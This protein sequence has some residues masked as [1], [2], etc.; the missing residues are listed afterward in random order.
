MA[1]EMRMEMPDYINTRVTEERQSTEK[2]ENSLPAGVCNQLDLDNINSTNG[3][4]MSPEN[5]IELL[6]QK[7]KMLEQLED[8]I[9]KLQSE[10]EQIKS[11]LA[12]SVQDFQG[13]PVGWLK[14]KQSC[15]QLNDE[16][17]DWENAHN[18]CVEK[19]SHLVI[20]DDADEMDF[21]DRFDPT[22]WIGLNREQNGSFTMW[23]WV[24][25]RRWTYRTNNW[26]EPSHESLNCAYADQHPTLHLVPAS[27]REEHGWMCEK[28]LK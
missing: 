7:D 6:Q 28:E 24:D 16:R 22:M 12:G 1:A 5:F 15:Y 19:S 10:N 3:T 13:C 2:T 27:C 11:V 4:L 26:L 14:Y 8:E 25:G 20:L 21:L 23:T 17:K 9:T 18:D